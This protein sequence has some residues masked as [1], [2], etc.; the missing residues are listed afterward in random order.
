MDAVLDKQFLS[1]AVAFVNTVAQAAGEK[2]LEIYRSTSTAEEV[3][4]EMKQEEGRESPLTKADL[5]ANTI[6]VEAL[7]EKYPQIPLLTEEARDDLKRLDSDF[8]WIIDPLDGTKDF[9]KRNGD[10]TV[11]IALVY[12]KKP[13]LGSVYTPVYSELYF[14]TDKGGA[15]YQQ[16]DGEVQQIHVSSVDNPTEMTIVC[17]RSHAKQGFTD[18]VTRHQ[19]KEVK[20]YGSSLKGCKI[21]QGL[22]DTYPRFG[23]TNEW[24]IAAMH[25]VVAEAGGMMTDFSG[26]ELTYNN[27]NTLNDGFLIS[28]GKSH[29]V[30]L[31]WCQEVLN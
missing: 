3:T 2:I 6:I 25:C 10:F 27:K 29:P 22:I 16:G 12:K 7:Q 24:D 28:N 13:V 9:L 21:A 23:P 20:K 19:F 30:L 15:F 1:E 4:L 31:S 11:N 18:L 5:A 17:S 14:A 26:E 8:V